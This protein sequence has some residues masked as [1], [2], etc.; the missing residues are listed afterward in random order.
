M[1]EKILLAGKAISGFAANKIRENDVVM[2]Y[3]WYVHKSTMKSWYTLY[4]LHCSYE[5]K[6]AKTS[7]NQI[8]VEFIVLVLTQEHYN[9]VVIGKAE[10]GREYV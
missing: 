3:A 1:E 4:I 8:W 5:L 9:M 10:D 6:P 2:I 7:S